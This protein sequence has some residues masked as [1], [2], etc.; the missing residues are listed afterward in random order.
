MELISINGV[1]A[2][3]GLDDAPIRE[4]A[5]NEAGNVFAA[6][7]L[8]GGSLEQ[9]SLESNLEQYFGTLPQHDADRFIAT[10]EQAFS[11]HMK[12]LEAAHA[13]RKAGERREG[14]K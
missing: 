11:T 5:E 3:K 10:F 7:T 13:V 1:T 8:G 14:I 6:I 9:R 4:F 2:L 12:T